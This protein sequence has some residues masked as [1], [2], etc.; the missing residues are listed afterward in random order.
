MQKTAKARQNGTLVAGIVIL[1]VAVFIIFITI[2]VPHVRENR[3][4][5]DKV[6]A[7]LYSDYERV[8]V[9]DPLYKNAAT[10]LDRGAEVLL[11]T[12][13][14]QQMRVLLQDVVQSGFRNVDN[15]SGAGGA[16]DMKCQLR[17]PD[18]TRTDLYFTEHEVYFYADGTAFCFAPKDLSAYDALFAYMSSLFLA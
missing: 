15:K 17:A 14:V 13:Q 16:W 12:A 9:S 6:H 3:I 11:S 18:G 1:F 4:L 10:P 8:V 7:L 5:E 2:A